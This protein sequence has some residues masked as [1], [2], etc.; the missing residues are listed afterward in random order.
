MG[1]TPVVR[2][3]MKRGGYNVLSMV[4]PKGEMK[5]SVT[6]DSV[7]S[8]HYIEFL[9][10]LIRDRER[11]LILL[12]D[13]ISFPRSQKVRDFVR[14]HRARLRIFFLPKRT[15]E[16]NPDEPVWNAIKNHRIGKQPVENIEPFDD[17]RTQTSTD[18]TDLLSKSRVDVHMSHHGSIAIF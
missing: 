13:R 7:D 12:V 16:M 8:V 6:A 11:P 14:A 3:C 4:T 2:V 18:N 15:P 1:K 5:Y 17:L 9:K 10:N